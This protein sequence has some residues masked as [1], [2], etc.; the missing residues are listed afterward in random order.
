MEVKVGTVE[1]LD[2]PRTSNKRNKSFGGGDK[3]SGNSGRR[4]GG[5]GG[6]DRSDGNDHA[7]HE[8]F[9]PQKY[10]VGMWIILILVLMTFSALISAYMVIAVNKQSEWKPMVLPY[11][12]WVSTVL[13]LMSSVTFEI[14]R[15]NLEQ[16]KQEIARRW[17]LDTTV[18]GAMIVASQ[19]LSWQQLVNDGILVEGNPYAGFFY[20]MTAT[21]ALHLLGGMIALGY[22]VLQVWQTTRNA[23]A[24]FRRQT[25]TNVV[26]LYWH[27]ID[28]LWLVLLGLLVF[29]K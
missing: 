20:I 7:E 19:L 12:V 1:T 3:G 6:G 8:E 14:A 26:S 25:L 9:K 5:G 27:T 16:A 17:L 22:L 13:L 23:E 2:E 11:Q 15:R 18:L 28:G 24:L 29:W 4:G 10:R 21:H